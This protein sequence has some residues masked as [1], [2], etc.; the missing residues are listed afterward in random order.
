MKHERENWLVD[1]AP[2]RC[3]R[4]RYCVNVITQLSDGRMIVRIG[5]GEAKGEQK[6]SLVSSDWYQDVVAVE[7]GVKVIVRQPA[8]GGREQCRAEMATDQ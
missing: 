1:S 8:A 5:P 7:T 6:T 4:D 2:I 3:L